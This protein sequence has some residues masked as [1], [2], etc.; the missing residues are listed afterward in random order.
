MG[1][2]TTKCQRCASI[3]R[4]T[5]TKIVSSQEHLHVYRGACLLDSSGSQIERGGRGVKA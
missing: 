2:I 3:E 4:L 1:V 5:S